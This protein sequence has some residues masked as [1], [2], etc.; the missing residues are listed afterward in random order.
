MAKRVSVIKVKDYYV[1]YE[2]FWFIKIKQER[3]KS[4]QKPRQILNL[5]FFEG[6]QKVEA[7][8]Q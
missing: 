4:I 3:Q 5:A 7:K 6:N 1:E 2:F 8:I